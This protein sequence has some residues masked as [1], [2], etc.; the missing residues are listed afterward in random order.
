[1]HHVPV[2]EGTR[3]EGSQGE[4]RRKKGRVRVGWREVERKRTDR[5]AMVLASQNRAVCAVSVGADVSDLETRSISN[6][7]IE[8]I[9][10]S[11]SWCVIMRLSAEATRRRICERARGP[12]RARK[13]YN[14]RWMNVWMS[15][16]SSWDRAERESQRAEQKRVE[17]RR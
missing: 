16:G 6:N 10:M 9:I 14:N 7:G 13:L 17:F 4:R 12:V 1:M 15:G 5:E 11:E 2:R 3:A 8:S